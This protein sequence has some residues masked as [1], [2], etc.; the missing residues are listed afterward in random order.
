MAHELGHNIG[1][2]H[3]FSERHGGSGSACNKGNH[4]M[5]YGDWTGQ[6]KFSSCSKKDLQTH[7]TFVK[8]MGSFDEYDSQ[9]VTAKCSGSAGH[10]GW[11]ND[12]RL[13]SCDD[14]LKYK[15]CMEG[16][17]VAY[18]KISVR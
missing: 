4:I 1:L 7:F 2:D 9:C 17:N 5:S 8:N 11:D 12:G 3:D 18:D 13:Q 6:T 10:M 16:N 14:C 15:W